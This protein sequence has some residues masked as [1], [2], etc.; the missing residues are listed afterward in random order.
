VQPTPPP[1]PA[2]PPV[3]SLPLPLYFLDKLDIHEPYGRI[4][5]KATTAKRMDNYGVPDVS[6]LFPT[7]FQETK[8]N[9]QH[10]ILASDHRAPPPP[11]LSWTTRTAPP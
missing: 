11:S 5:A 6:P 9:P 2:P 7:S 8:P 3:P 4:R 10:R 1:T